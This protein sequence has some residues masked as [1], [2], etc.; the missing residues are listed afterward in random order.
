MALMYLLVDNE[1]D[2]WIAMCIHHCVTILLVIF[3][4][5]TLHHQEGTMVQI[6][7][8][9]VDIFLYSAKACH[10]LGIQM[11]ANVLFMLFVITKLLCRLIYFPWVII[12]PGT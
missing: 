11:G 4:Y 12:I 6:A 9:F 3:S 5:M 8:D 1:L 7:H 2:D 10:N